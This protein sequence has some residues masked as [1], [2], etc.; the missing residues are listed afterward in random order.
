M[1][2]NIRTASI[3]SSNTHVSAQEAENDSDS[4]QLTLS[5]YMVSIDYESNEWYEDKRMPHNEWRGSITTIVPF[6]HNWDGYLV[7]LHTSCPETLSASNFPDMNNQSAF[8]EQQLV[9]DDD[10]EMLQRVALIARGDHCS[11]ATKVSHAGSIMSMFNMTLSGIIIYDNATTENGDDIKNW[12]DNDLN[13]SSVATTPVIV[14]NNTLGISL[15]KT[16]YYEP[17]SITTFS[18]VL[19]FY[20]KLPDGSTNDGGKKK[21]EMIEK[22][23]STNRLIL[24]GQL[25]VNSVAITLVIILIAYACNRFRRRQQQLAARRMMNQNSDGVSSSSS[26]NPSL[27]DSTTSSFLA[28]MRRH[29]DSVESE[30]EEAGIGWQQLDRF[31]KMTYDPL[32]IRNSTCA[33]C[34]DDFRVYNATDEKATPSTT[35]LL[36]RLKCGHGFCVPCIGEQTRTRLITSRRLQG[37]I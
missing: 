31:P 22:Q 8:A 15:L 17:D 37:R 26:E 7:N 13:T 29:H 34:L 14:I 16:L 3:D 5:Q 2:K 20:E 27:I 4:P 10:K 36:R 30:N 21:D 12:P 9:E 23:Q 32:V 11:W 6:H 24:A 1:C 33:I 35:K 18:K 28:I 19:A 25:I